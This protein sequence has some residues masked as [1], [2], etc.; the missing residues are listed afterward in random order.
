MQMEECE[1]Y[2]NMMN[3]WLI[4]AQEGK[5]L[6][7]FIVRQGWQRIAVYGMSIYGRHVIRDLKK[8]ECMVVCGIDRKK[9][10]PYEGVEILEPTDRLPQVDAVVNT[11]LHRHKEIVLDLQKVILC[12]VVSLEDVVFESY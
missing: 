4:L 5:S 7:R 6:E 8:T 11:V 10:C 12:P 9:M 2:L 1:Q 3:Q